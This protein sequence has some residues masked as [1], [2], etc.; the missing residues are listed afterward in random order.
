MRRLPALALVLALVSA[1][2]SAGVPAVPIPKDPQGTGAPV[3]IGGEASPAPIAAA[4]VP[5]HPYMAANGK[6]NIHDDAYMSDAYATGG[7]LGHGG[8]D[9][10]VRSTL[11]VAECASVTFDPAG[12][13]VTICVGLEGPRLVMLDPNTLELLAAMP[14]PPR[15]PVTAASALSDFSGGGYFY[16]D[17]LG[18]AVIPTNDHRILV[19]GE[20]DDP[21]PA[22]VVERIYDLSLVVGVDEGILSVL[23]DWNGLLWFVTA[24]GLVGTVDPET[25]AVRSVRLVDPTSGSQEKIG[26]SFAVDDDGGVYIVTEYAMYRFDA[27][28]TAGAPVVTW[29]EAY[30]RG[31]RLKPGQVNFGSGTTPTVI[32]DQWVAITDNADPKMHVLVYRRGASV[33]GDRLV[34]EQSVFA[35]GK[36]ATDN[37]LVGFATNAGGSIIVENNYGYSGLTATM[38]GGVTEPGVA[39][40]DFTDSSAGTDCSTV[41]TNTSERAPS[42][43]SKLSL[44][45]G[46]FYAYTKDPQPDNTDVWYLTAI[47]FADGTTAFKRLVGTGFGYNNNWAPVTLSPDGKTAYVGVLGGLVMLRDAAG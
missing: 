38:N 39:R 45:N 5:P 34:C 31:T 35:D 26:N 6:S 17:N 12:R 41:W 2:A 22:F 8:A 29:R 36:S 25:G 7:P 40:I 27:D 44:A 28:P 3:F 4:P 19:V 1:A 23:P 30:D 33:T 46:L 42:S 11:H 14:L 9:M 18:R 15:S 13:I 16:L 24:K 21:A 10:E 32:G 43:V 47:K 20:I 37:S